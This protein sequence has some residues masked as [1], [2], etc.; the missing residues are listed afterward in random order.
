MYII[1]GATGRV[2]SAVAQNLLDQGQ[3]VTI[4]THNPKK[5]SE[6][7]QKGAHVAIAD[8]H[9]TDGLRRVF[10]Q[11]KRL[12]LLNPP[13]AP[14]TDSAQE[15]R[16]S[17]ASILAAL[18]DADLEKIVAQSTYGAQPGNRIGD[19][20]VLYEME[21]GLA[22]LSIPFSIVRAAYYMSNWDMAFQTAQQE[23]KVYTFYP[24]N[25]K[26]PMA[27]PQDLGRI[28]AQL[29]M[30]PLSQTGLH[31]AEGPEPYSSTD[32]AAAFAVALD[33]PVEAIEIPRKQWI[34]AL[35]EAG[36][37]QAAAESMAEMTAITLE[38]R[39][40]LPDSPIRGTTTLREYIY[41][42]VKGASMRSS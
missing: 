41:Q 11:G 39:Y 24:P 3:P 9:D 12:F 30:E 6:W 10:R 29:L 16:K 28:A 32:V 35:K 34:P 36:F 27:A 15:E 33:K 40:D 38:Q 17:I 37:S 14:D 26:I 23:G 18:V 8:V 4:I 21:Q 31:Y 25:F 2:G 22:R 7:E 20:G 1:L 5:S 19:L 42:I 13:A